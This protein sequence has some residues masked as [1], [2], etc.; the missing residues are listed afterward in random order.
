MSPISSQSRFLL[1][2]PEGPADIASG[3]ASTKR[4]GLERPSSEADKSKNSWTSRMSLRT[5]HLP[6]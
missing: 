5:P 4:K 3:T 6:Y 1:I 2:I